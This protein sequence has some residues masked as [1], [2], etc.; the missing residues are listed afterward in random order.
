M[1]ST[2]SGWRKTEAAKTEVSRSES[3]RSAP[4]FFIVGHP[5][6]GT[7]ALY[8]ILRGHPEIYM[9]D[10]KETRFFARE[11]HPPSGRRR[12]LPE[13]LEEYLALFEPA[14]PGQRTGEASP[15]YLRSQHAAARIAE[16][17]PDARIIAILRE[18]A[19]F[20]RSLHME[21]LRDRVE[22]EADLLRALALE[23]RRSEPQERERHP[24][25]VYGD[26]VQYVEQLRR[27][28]EAFG[29]NQLKVLIYDDF[30]ADNEGT[31]RDVL[32]FL[33]VDEHAPLQIV[34][35]N[36]SVRVRSQRAQRFT[37]SLYMG[38]GPFS[39]ALK[40]MVKTAL[41]RRVRRDALGVVQRN[42]VFARPGSADAR[43]TAEL[44]ARYRDEVIAL[45]KHLDRD[46]SG[47][48][49]YDRLG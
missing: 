13:T 1:T 25:L 43:T 36:P 34:D 44:Q 48:W 2:Q 5:K 18:P 30:R 29:A 6:C 16:L 7:T 31:I 11:L 8:E 42:V 22:P 28:E 24:G 17:R 26:Y 23:P 19:S 15:S 21:L 12:I 3:A 20:I 38:R 27:Y 33:E 47:L 41:P 9:P 14:R 10:L 45:G 49:G 40:R 39:G 37:R 35:A 46:L 4:D 32:R